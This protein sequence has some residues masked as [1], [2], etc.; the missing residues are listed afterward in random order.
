MTQIFSLILPRRLYNQP[1]VHLFRGFDTDGLGRDADRYAVGPVIALQHRSADRFVINL[2]FKP[3]L[4]SPRL[5][6]VNAN[7]KIRR[8]ENYRAVL[9]LVHVELQHHHD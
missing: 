8:V 3:L 2:A 5:I 4:S 7:V 9:K 6:D 1:V